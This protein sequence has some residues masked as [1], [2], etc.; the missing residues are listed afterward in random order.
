MRNFTT[1]IR[2]LYKEPDTNTSSRGALQSPNSRQHRTVLLRYLTHEAVACAL[3]RHLDLRYGHSSRRHRA[4]LLL[5]YLTRE[6]VACTLA[7]PIRVAAAADANIFAVVHL[8]NNLAKSAREAKDTATP[9]LTAA[10]ATM[11][12]IVFAKFAPLA[13]DAA[14][15]AVAQCS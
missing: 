4:V 14:D 8:L 6:A 11:N 9:V 3:T 10:A 12:T 5:R 1:Y 15:A 13:A 2:G 7:G